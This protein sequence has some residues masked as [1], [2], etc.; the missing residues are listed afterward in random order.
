MPIDLTQIKKKILPPQ[1]GQDEL[2]LR[3][4]VISAVNADGTVDVV[5]SG[6]T[7]PSVPRLGGS[8]VAVGAVV[9]ILSYRGSLLVIG[10]TASGGGASGGLGLWTR[11][12]SVTASGGVGTTLTAVLTTP[13]VTFLRNRVYEIKSQGGGSP[14]A[15]NS[16]AEL[17]AFR[18]GGA[19][20]GEWYRFPA[21]TTA[22]INLTV[23]GIY[24]AVSNSG[25]VTG[26]VQ[27]QMAWSTGTT[28]SHYANATSERNLEVWDVGDASQFSGIQTW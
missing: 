21:L 17:R 4:G 2:K 22:V 15:A 25:N 10:G 27:L 13:T 24:F 5:I 18:S 9:Q 6:V 12:R 11:V 7:V 20:L 28:G 26:A 8:S 16:I 3:T 19:T 14:P 23:G 1:D